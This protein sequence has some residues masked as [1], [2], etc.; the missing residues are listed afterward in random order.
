MELD[1]KSI[2]FFSMSLASS[3]GVLRIIDLEGSKIYHV[4]N[5]LHVG[6]R[7]ISVRVRWISSHFHDYLT[8]NFVT[9]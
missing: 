7:N 5:H 4:K 9:L 6:F 3:K 1:P 2:F 8:N